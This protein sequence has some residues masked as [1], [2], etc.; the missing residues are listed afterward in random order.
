MLK[1]E[2]RTYLQYRVYLIAQ[3]AQAT[4]DMVGQQDLTCSYQEGQINALAIA[5]EEHDRLFSAGQPA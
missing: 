1:K 3:L 4:K 2:Y 5:L